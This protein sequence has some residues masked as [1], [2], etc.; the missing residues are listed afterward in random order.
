VPFGVSG[1]FGALHDGPMSTQATKA[2]LAP[3]IVAL[4]SLASVSLLGFAVAF[5][6]EEPAATTPNPRSE[7]ETRGT[8]PF[9]GSSF[10]RVPVPQRRSKWI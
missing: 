1:H 7:P 9:E 2:S 3:I 10:T 4:L 5:W 8:R 6:P